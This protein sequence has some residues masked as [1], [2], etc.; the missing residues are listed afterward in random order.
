MSCVMR[1]S[2]FC[3]CE[4]STDQLCGNLT[5]DQR[6]SFRYTD[7]T[8]PLLHKYENI[9]LATFFGCTARFVWELV[10]NPED[11]FSHNEAQKSTLQSTHL[12]V[13]EP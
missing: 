13:M 10:G 8:I 4:N 1:K 2:A 12:K 3:I 6:L 7:S 11:R 5:A 9:R